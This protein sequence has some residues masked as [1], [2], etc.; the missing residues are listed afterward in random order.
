MAPLNNGDVLDEAEIAQVRQATN[1][2]NATLS[3]QASAHAWPVVDMN[4]LFKKTQ[5]GYLDFFGNSVRGDLLE[6]GQLSA[7]SLFSVDAIHPN[8]RGYAFLANEFIDVINQA[9][10]AQIPRLNISQFSGLKLTP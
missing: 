5:A 4:G 1:A 3:A 6:N 7:N 10:K 9:Y 2:F 8:A